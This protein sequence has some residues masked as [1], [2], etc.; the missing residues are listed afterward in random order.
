MTPNKVIDFF[1]SRIGTPITDSPSKAARWL[2]PV[3]INV[4]EGML[5]AEFEVREDM[6][7]PMGTIHGGVVSFIFD[8]LIGATV[9]TLNL[10][11][12]FVTTNLTVDYLLSAKQG[13]KIRAKAFVV[14]KGR[15]VI[16][17]RAELFDHKNRLIA[18]A[19]SNLVHT[20][21]QKI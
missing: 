5:E 8:E 20:K 2:K 4:A 14:R 3:I 6:T 21:A 10:P 18:H 17:T 16:N 7:N 12:H 11:T 15:N 1:K 19:S 9:H 13:E